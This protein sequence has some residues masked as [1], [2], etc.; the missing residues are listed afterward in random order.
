MTKVDPGAIAAIC[1]SVVTIAL[2]ARYKLTPVQATLADLPL[3]N[4]VVNSFSH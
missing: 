2:L 4:S 1:V 3:S